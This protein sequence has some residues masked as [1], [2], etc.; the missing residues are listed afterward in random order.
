ME[1]NSF[2]TKKMVIHP[3]QWDLRTLIGIR[4]HLMGSEKPFHVEE[5][6]EFI[7]SMET[8]YDMFHKF[9]AN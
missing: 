7:R 4:E 3:P 9:S 5:H 8:G 2:E 1:V 6:V